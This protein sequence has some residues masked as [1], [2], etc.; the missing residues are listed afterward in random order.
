[1]PPKKQPAKKFELRSGGPCTTV[2]NLFA[3]S[4]CALFSPSSSS[5][6]NP[7]SGEDATSG[8]NN[9]N[10]ATAGNGEILKAI[11][12]MRTEFNYRFE[13]ILS[14]LNNVQ[15]DVKA[16]AGRITEAE[17]RISGAE[18]NITALQ[19]TVSTLEKKVESLSA[20]ALEIEWR[21]R[22][23]Q[24][25]LA[26]LPEGAEGT[27]AI[28]FLEGWLPEVLELGPLRNPIIIEKAHRIGNIQPNSTHPRAMIMRFLSHRD[29]MRV[30][31]AAKTK[32]KILYKNVQVM[33]FQ[34][35]PREI[36]KQ[37]RRYTDV[38]QKLRAKGFQCGI[39]FPSRLWVTKGD[40][41]N[42]FQ[43]PAEAERFLDNLGGEEEEG[44]TPVEETGPGEREDEEEEEDGAT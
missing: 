34:D 41:S 29:K 37:Q 28:S 39:I 31:N 16:C 11:M 38:K 43:T 19:T 7:P 12:D 36:H 27:N 3:P 17:E 4:A 10:N 20:K 35:L 23:N 1:M 8:A 22:K 15:V 26:F 18:D 6:P 25:R 14:A 33:F 24:L 9:M 32:R 42:Y 40:S 2:D 30:D 5:R 44:E 13:S 21:S